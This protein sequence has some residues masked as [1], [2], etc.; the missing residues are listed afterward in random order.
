MNEEDLR[1]IQSLLGRQGHQP[2]TL[3]AF[4][5]FSRWWSPLL[6]TL[7]LVREEWGSVAPVLV[8]GFMARRTAE[9]RLKGRDR[10]TFLLRFSESRA[11]ALVIT[12]SD[13]ARQAPGASAS[14]RASTYVQHC[15]V[16]I[17]PGGCHVNTE[18][19]EVPYTS[20]GHLITS[21]SMLR[22]LYPNV[23]KHEVFAHTR[24]H[25][26]SFPSEG[27]GGSVG[28]EGEGG[29]KD[30]GWGGVGR[31]GGCRGGGHGK[32]STEL[33]DGVDGGRVWGRTSAADV[34]SVVG[35]SKA[36]LE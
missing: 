34:A 25:P 7:S 15:L 33:L 2:D 12:F 11:G 28:G 22:V 21:S 18:G 13:R 30:M 6:K 17:H 8:H 16:H 35:P 26:L 9:K 24:G 36:E 23:P 14:E 27:G 1:F 4:V 19:R 3:A 10:G 29:R 31:V 5:G 32:G 20:L